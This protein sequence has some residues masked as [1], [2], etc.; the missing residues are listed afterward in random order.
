MYEARVS[1][2][3]AGTGEGPG[4]VLTL[5]GIELEADGLVGG[6]AE[7]QSVPAVVGGEADHLVEGS[8]GQAE[9]G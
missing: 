6:A 4:G 8:A 1:G 7:F 9:G 3:T 2:T 5:A